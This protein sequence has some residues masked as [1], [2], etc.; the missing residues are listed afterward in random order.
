LNRTGCELLGLPLQQVLNTKCYD[1]FKT[2]DC[3]TDNCACASAMYRACRINRE[4]DAHPAGMDL[5]IQYTGN[6]IKDGSGAVIGAMET[7][8]DLT[9]IR[10]AQRLAEKQA[11]YQA[12]EVD[13]LIAN[14]EKLG[15][16]DMSVETSIA[17]ADEDTKAV[18]Q[19]F[20]GI[21]R[22]LN[23]CAG[24]ISRLIS[25]VDSLAEAA[26]GGNLSMRADT[27]GHGG[28]YLRIVEGVNKT[29]DAVITPVNE[30]AG[31]LRS[32]AEGDLSTMM[33]GDYRGDHAVIKDTLNTT[34]HSINSILH[35]VREAAAQVNAGALQVA[36]SSLSLSQGATQQ[37]AA[38]EEITSSMTQLAAQTRANAENASQ[39]NLL[40]VSARESAEHGALQLEEM[41]AAM[42]EINEAS[43]SIAR[44]IKVIDEI[45]FQTNLLALNAAVEAAR[46][47]RHGKGFAVVA[48]EVRN[49]A[50]R[51]A[52][53]ARETTELIESS[54]RKVAKG[55]EIAGKSAEALK[56]IVVASTKTTDLVGEIAAASNEQAQGIAQI[57]QGLGQIDSVTQQNTANAEQTAAASEELSGQSSELHRHLSRFRLRNEEG[58]AKPPAL[59]ASRREFSLSPKPP[60]RSLPENGEWGRAPASEKKAAPVD[61]VLTPKDIIALDDVEFGKY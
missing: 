7:M 25:D 29:L 10:K 55:S 20:A 53:A 56:E 45:A 30:A 14:L 41:V 58:K 44:I 2:S 18:A 1:H 51:S 42:K 32:M 43:R 37:A 4:T 11:G 39:A 3:R 27:S 50:G 26:V 28:D 49:L 31:S 35:Q 40:A 12:R 17:P 5:D 9:A 36:D 19:N 38:L 24:A 61:R 47:G 48:E 22:S 8:V 60:V 13:R 15:R 52:R 57:N 33:K 6:P 16:G 23:Q 21:N 54:V 34:L 46:A 59:P